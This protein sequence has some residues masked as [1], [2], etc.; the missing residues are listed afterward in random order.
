MMILTHRKPSAKPPAGLNPRYSPPHTRTLLC[1][2]Q[3]D[4]DAD[5]DDD[6]DN[7]DDDDDDDDNDDDDDKRIYVWPLAHNI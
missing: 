6:D 5:D 3:D 1:L 2:V 4:A 7:D